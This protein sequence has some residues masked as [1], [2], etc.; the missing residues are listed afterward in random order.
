MDALT[1][2]PA[3][4]APAPTP[5]P[6]PV[7]APPFLA[8]VAA[9][10]KSTQPT[11]AFVWS[12]I[13][14]VTSYLWGLF[15][16]LYAL[17]WTVVQ[18]SVKTIGESYAPTTSPPGIVTGTDLS[19]SFINSAFTGGIFT[20]ALTAG[21]LCAHG[22]TAIISGLVPN[23]LFAFPILFV[24]HLITQILTRLKGGSDPFAAVRAEAGT[25]LAPGPVSALGPQYPVPPPLGL[26]LD[27]NPAATR[28]DA[29]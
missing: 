8:R 14:A 28:W 2:T 5:K 11:R 6:T 26:A 17:A 19:K 22:L 12:L 25:N 21:L 7:P 3:A 9:W 20:F 10:W 15:A 13:V 27:P 1:P 24:L 4:P 29:R 18:N 16:R 23:P